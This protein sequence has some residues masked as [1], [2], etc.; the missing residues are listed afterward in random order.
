MAL[1][2]YL[3][4]SVAI[5]VGTCLQCSLGFGLG[6]LCAPVLALLE[7]T[8][9]PGPLLL[10]AVAI[11]CVLT[12]LGRKALQFGELGWAMA[13]R[14]PGTIAAVTLLMFLPTRGLEAFFGVTV[15][16]A[17]VL[18]VLG[19][20]PVVN[21]PTLVG[22]GAVSGLMGTA[23]ST[24][25]A[26]L[27]WLLQERHGDRL[28]TSLSTFFFAGTILSIT[29]LTVTGQLGL[30]QLRDAALLLPGVAVGAVGSRRAARA[31]DPRTTRYAV[32]GISGLAS[33]GLLVRA[34]IG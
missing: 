23:V 16:L 20:R 25:A 2:T 28:R 31:L 29:G 32:L 22:A 21:R 5:A 7:P 11:T 27:A 26:P 19:L 10:L 14:V 1:E 4:A 33:V 34:L 3:L 6:L 18:S 9:I 15:L 8:L 30:A 12:V 13:G 17:V 24:G